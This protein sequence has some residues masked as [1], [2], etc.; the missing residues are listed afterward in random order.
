MID[1]R[2]ASL[3]EYPHAARMRRQMSV[4]HDGDFDLRSNGW[5]QRF[6][7]YFASKQRAGRG[8]LFLAYDGDEAIGMTIV[9]ILEHYRNDVF[10]T[11][12]A[13]VNG[14]Y[15]T[16]SYRRRGIA[17]KLMDLAI[18]WAREAGCEQI[19]LRSSEAGKPLY[20]ALG[21]APTTEMSLR[22]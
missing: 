15:V 19:R 5:R 6:C 3:D 2:P 21:F 4:E 18:G 10:G 14:V 7:E 17:R 12:Y 8:Q 22:L 16:S 9:S 13:Y 1:Y 11:K 20:R